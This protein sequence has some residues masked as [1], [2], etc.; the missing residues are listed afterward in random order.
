MPSFLT[1]AMLPAVPDCQVHAEKAVDQQH[2]PENRILHIQHVVCM[3][4]GRGNTAEYE[5]CLKQAQVIQEGVLE[6]VRGDHPDLI[7]AHKQAAAELQMELA[8]LYSSQQKTDQ[9]ITALLQPCLVALGAVYV[10]VCGLVCSL[11]ADYAKA[12][13]MLGDSYAL[14][15]MRIP[16]AGA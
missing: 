13:C 4:Q 1:L 2:H 11:Q 7:A 9:V 8:H 10:Y 5:S 3:L 6:G 14:N 12:D 15:H 16:G